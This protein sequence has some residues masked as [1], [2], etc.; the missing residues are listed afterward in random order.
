[1]ALSSTTP[2]GHGMAPT[3]FWG[4]E[5]RQGSRSSIAAYLIP[6]GVWRDSV[7]SRR[8]EETGAMQV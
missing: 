5:C 6:M 7:R 2:Y 3:F 8:N 4:G 1:M